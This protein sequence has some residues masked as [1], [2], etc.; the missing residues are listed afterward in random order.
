MVFPHILL[1]LSGWRENSTELNYSP[2]LTVATNLPVVFEIKVNNIL[3]VAIAI[4]RLVA[5]RWPIL[6]KKRPKLLYVTGS[7]AVGCSWGAVDAILL[8]TTTN[9]VPRI[10]CAA[11]GCFAAQ[12]FRNYKGIADMCINFVAMAATITLLLR[13][14]RLSS[15]VHPAMIAALY[16]ANSRDQAAL[17]A[18]SRNVLVFNAS[19]EEEKFKNANRIVASVLLISG[20]C[21]FLP[22]LFA[23]FGEMFHIGAFQKAGP[24]VAVG[25]LL[26]GC[27]NAVVYGMNHSAVRKVKIITP[28]TPLW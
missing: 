14:R 7:I 13:L 5:V 28:F 23:G 21:I 9:F 19:T 6:Y 8:L 22:S 2:L 11:A 26:S 15:I 10:G 4:D 27:L 3:T 24:F 16:S 1:L 17:N 12:S 25:L 20:V 18:T